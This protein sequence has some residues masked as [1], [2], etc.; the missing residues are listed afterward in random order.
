M[1]RSKVKI[2]AICDI[3]N[4]KRAIKNASRKKRHRRSVAVYLEN[5]DESARL[6]SEYIKDPNMVLHDGY[7][8]VI[9][10]GTQKKRREICKPRFFPDHCVH[11]AVMQVVGDT[12]AKSNYRYSCAS[13]KGRGVHY[14]KRAVEKALKDTRG[15]KYCLQIDVK[16]FYASIDKELLIKLLGRKFKDARIV[17]VMAKIVRSYSGEGLPIG[18]YTSATFANFYLTES[19]RYIKE[20]LQIKHMVR[21][22]DDIVIYDGN[23]RKLHKTKD[24][25][26]ANIRSTRGLRLKPNWQVYKMPYI[27]GKPPKD[28]KERRRPTDFVGFKFYRYKTTIR[29]SIFKRMRRCFLKLASGTYTTHR[30]HTFM[31]YYGY[32]KHTNSVGVIK[33]YI[34]GGKILVKKLK[35]LIRNENRNQNTG[36]PQTAAA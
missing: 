4:C 31:S 30:A 9:N 33:R 27:R 1:K 23:K 19:D 28:Y 12:F 10:E 29:K 13:I 21:Y 11:W 18:F 14:A 26:E 34:D 25:I 7:Q 17:A 20:T 2:E 22:M 16:S 24:Q 15:T 35:E 3:D 8:S 6:L 36:R 5:L 32:L